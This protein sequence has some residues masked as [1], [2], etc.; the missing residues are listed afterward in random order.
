MARK[1]INTLIRETQDE[2]IEVINSNLQVGIPHSVIELVLENMLI[3][4]N[5]EINTIIQQE[6]KQQQEEEELEKGVVTET[7]I[8]DGIEEGG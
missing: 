4:L 2:L 5:N 6:V 1:C 3:K 8:V 7:C